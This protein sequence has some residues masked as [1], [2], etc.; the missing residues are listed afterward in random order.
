MERE[1]RLYGPLARFVGQRSFMAEVRSAGEAIR[2]LLANFP[3]LERHMADNHYKV[4]VDNYES[5]LDEINNPASG[6]IQ[7]IP[8]VVGAWNPFKALGKIFVGAALIVGAIFLAPAAG[9]FLAAGGLINAAG[10]GFTG[11]A[12]V[13]SVVGTIGASMVL[14]GVAQLISP[15]PQIQ[16]PGAAS[17]F[18]PVRTTEGGPQD[19]QGRDSYSFSGIQNTSR[20][21]SCVPCVFGETVVGS[22]VISAGLDV[23]DK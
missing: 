18:Q 2:M 4:V 11:A 23:D 3:G 1:I 8:V 17:S 6:C 14:G 21:G 22:V 15:T 16:Q 19:P 7:I 13:S 10:A 5:D 9:G 20:Q 12:L